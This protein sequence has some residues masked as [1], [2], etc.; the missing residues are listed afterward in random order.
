MTYQLATVSDEFLYINMTPKIKCV[1][2]QPKTKCS[3]K[4][5]DSFIQVSPVDL[6]NIPVAKLWTRRPTILTAKYAT[7]AEAIANFEVRSDDIWI[8][9]FPKCGT[10]WAMEMVR[11]LNTDLDYEQAANNPLETYFTFIEGVAYYDFKTLANETWYATCSVGRAAAR[12]SPRYIKCHL[13][14]EL[15]PKSIWTVRPKIIFTARNPKDTAVSFYHHYRNMQGYQQDMATFMKVFLADE[16]L[17]SPFYDHVLNFWYSR[18]EPNMLFLTYEQMKSD[19]MA[20]L[21]KT[22]TF[23]GKS[24]TAEQL[25]Q[26]NSHLHVDSMRNNGSSNNTRLLEHISDNLGVGCVDPDFK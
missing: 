19:M 9:T 4:Y 6:P 11:L 10:T 14:I 3:Y 12:S 7:I 2:F 22:Q 13:P 20:V 1:P 26:L 17:Y 15:L 18:D 16:T 24:F 5:G 25:E 8:V 23:L 21:R